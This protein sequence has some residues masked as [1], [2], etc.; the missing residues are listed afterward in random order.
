[1]IY[2]YNVASFDAGTSQRNYHHNSVHAN[3]HTQTTQA[4]SL[5]FDA[6]TSQRNYHH[7][8]VHTTCTHKQPKSTP[9]LKKNT[10]RN[11]MDP[12]LRCACEEL[13]GRQRGRDVSSHIHT[14]CSRCIQGLDKGLMQTLHLLDSTDNI[15]YRPWLISCWCVNMSQ[16]LFLV[17]T[18]HVEVR[19]YQ[20]SVD[21][22]RRWGSSA[23]VCE[24]SPFFVTEASNPLDD[25]G[26]RSLEL[27]QKL[28]VLVRQSEDCADH[29]I[30]GSKKKRLS[31]DKW[32]VRP[33]WAVCL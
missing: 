28:V 22:V 11:R 27:G 32:V 18:R 9:D 21:E 20:V 13:N 14:C 24:R 29:P 5:S 19:F 15:F 26:H 1:M 23:P 17:G 3:M 6:G 10:L 25:F 4:T 12:Q 2:Y 33:T 30:D 31:R 8:N 16:N 7:D